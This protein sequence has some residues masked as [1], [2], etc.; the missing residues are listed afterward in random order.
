MAKVT[1]TYWRH[2]SKYSEEEKNLVDA[3]ER[4]DNDV[5]YGLASPESIRTASGKVLDDEEI[6]D[7]WERHKELEKLGAGREQ[8]RL[9]SLRDETSRFIAWK[10]VSAIVRR[11]RWKPYIGNSHGIAYLVADIWKRERRIV[12]VKQLRSMTPAEFWQRLRHID[13]YRVAE[14]ERNIF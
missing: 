4:A 1:Y 5:G 3:L 11:M 2:F 14:V 8:Q 7:Y 9:L 13:S 6:Y 12:S 10:E